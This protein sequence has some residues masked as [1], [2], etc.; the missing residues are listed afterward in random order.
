MQSSAPRIESENFFLL[1]SNS[2]PTRVVTEG[3]RMMDSMY[4]DLMEQVLV[5]M[6]CSIVSLVVIVILI[7]H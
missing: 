6:V 4:V 1:P 5:V 3:N 2:F 7:G